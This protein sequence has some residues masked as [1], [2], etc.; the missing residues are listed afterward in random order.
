[1]SRLAA[2]KLA[3]AGV[4]P[5]AISMAGMAAGVL[6]G[7][8]LASTSL[9]DEPWSRAAWLLG[10]LF[11]Q[12]RLA[13]NL[14]DGMVA[15]ATG[16]TSPVG[17]LYNEVPDRVSD[18]ATLAGL[19]YA[20]GGHP[21]LGWAAA[22]AA[23][24]TAYV[25]AMGKAAGAPQDYR[26]PMAKPHRMFIVTVTA[27]WCAL[28]PRGGNLEVASGQ[29]GAAALALAIIAA[30]SLL[31]CLRRLRRAADVLRGVRGAP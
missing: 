10:A 7:L 9:V 19:G 11:V 12:A 6:A 27:L 1:M 5:N 15:V 25:R 20:S 31:T 23:V 26:G 3:R 30:G 4:S 8:L 17:E 29:W 22:C 24:L 18:I 13:A 2:E 28:A 16:R 14:L 21:I